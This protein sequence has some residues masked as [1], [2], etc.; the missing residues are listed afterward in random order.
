MH[1]T[2]IRIDEIVKVD[3]LPSHA[4]GRATFTNGRTYA[5]DVNFAHG[6]AEARIVVRHPT[7]GKT[8]GPA[9]RAARAIHDRPGFTDIARRGHD[10]IAAFEYE[11]V[12]ACRQLMRPGWNR[13]PRIERID[14]R[15]P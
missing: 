15:A 3:G 12:T 7:D 11:R 1:L 5:F 8:M 4:R 2:D 9:T 13:E 10:A 14:I 6:C